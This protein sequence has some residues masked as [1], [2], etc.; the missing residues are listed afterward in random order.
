MVNSQRGACSTELATYK[1]NIFNKRELNNR[2]LKFNSILIAQIPR[3]LAFSSNFS[4]TVDAISFIYGNTVYKLITEIEGTNPSAR[5]A[6][7]RG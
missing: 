1:V 2:F 5:N 4:V 7:I 3:N 6:V